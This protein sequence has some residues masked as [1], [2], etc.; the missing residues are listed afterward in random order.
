MKKQRKKLFTIIAATLSVLTVLNF[1][2]VLT[3][4]ADNT[5]ETP[6]EY[7]DANELKDL[8]GGQAPEVYSNDDKDSKYIDGNYTN[9]KVNNESDAVKSINSIKKFVNIDNPE[10]EFKVSKVNKSDSLTS[11]KLQQVYNSVPLYG[12]EMVVVTDKQ[13]NATSVNGNYLKDVKVNTTPQITENA[14]SKYALNAYGKN[15]KILSNELTIYSLNDV[16]PT[17]CWKVTVKKAD[18]K[19]ASTVDS[20]IDASNGNVLTEVSLDH[21]ATVQATGTDLNGNNRTFNVNKTTTYSWFYGKRT[22]YQL[23]DSVRN[24]K[25]SNSGYSGYAYNTPMTSMNNVWNDKSSV[26]AMAN[27]ST[28]Y[29]F[30]KNVLNR[31]SYD[32]NGAP[33][34]GNI[35]VIDAEYGI[36]LDNAYWSQYYK[37][38]FFGDGYQYFSPLAGALDVTAH[39]FTHAVSDTISNF[40]YQ[41]ESGALSEAYSDILGYLIEGKDDPKWLIGED[42]VTDKFPYEALRNLSNPEAYKYPSK[43]KGNN[44]HETYYP[45]YNDDNDRGGVHSNC[46]VVSHTAYLM[47]KNGI[48]DK[49]KLAKLFFMNSQATFK[50]CRAAVT[51]AAKA[52]KMNSTELNIINNAFD[53]TGITLQ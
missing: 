15:S 43:Y 32:D 44:W 46:N 6:Q 37:Q 5:N 47:W 30:Y 12:R 36:P 34:T 26:S 51:S 1:N 9:I 29:D 50:D 28:V 21:D 23:Y 11:Y 31:T 8:N 48:T 40:T 35:H 4:A 22:T 41:S 20:F 25:I 10:K 42:I 53:E 13:G 18:T 39:E 19:K 33:I 27:L 16:N 49:S 17:L 3:T 45:E 52:L 24:I 38:F 2:V 7:S 14:V